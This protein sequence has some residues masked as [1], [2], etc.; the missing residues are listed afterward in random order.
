MPGAAPDESA[1][2]AVGDAPAA[3]EREFA[4]LVVQSAPW[5]DVQVK[6]TRARWYRGKRP[7][8]LASRVTFSES[9]VYVVLDINVTELGNFERD[10]TT[11]DTW[12][13]ILADGTRLRSVNSLGVNILTGDSPTIPL[14]YL[15]TEDTP[16]AGASLE[17]NGTDRETFEPMLIPLDRQASF[18]SEIVLS[19]LVGQVITPTAGGDLT[20]EVLDA[21]YG[22]NLTRAGRRAPRD[23]RL[24]LLNCRVSVSS[25]F[26]KSYDGTVEGPRVSVN[27]NSQAATEGAL[28]TIYRDESIE[29][30]TLYEIDAKATAFDVIFD[31]DGE[32]FTRVPVPLP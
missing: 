14:Y 2:V 7:D 18:E 23:R 31:T 27:G 25:I 1:N 5:A 15:A 6:V 13:L 12:D 20:F 3:F 4:G 22:V 11:R 28:D 29:S 16:L 30:Q 26:G 9:N 24:V 17:I 19:S 10:Y 21:A 32:T 8:D